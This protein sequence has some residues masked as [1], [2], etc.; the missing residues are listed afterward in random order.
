MNEEQINRLLRQ[1][2][3][4]C[5]PASLETRVLAAIAAQEAAPA[6]PAATSAAPPRGFLQWSLPARAAFLATALGAAV[7]TLKGLGWAATDVKSSLLG[8]VIGAVFD[9]IPT[10][11]LYSA[12]GAVGMLYLMFFGLG[13]VAY[14][15][16]FTDR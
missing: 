3:L 7:L 5:A 10:L 11:W 9:Q 1:Q 2:P 12:L 13:A 8:T 15:T 4:R 14:R 16:L 6:L